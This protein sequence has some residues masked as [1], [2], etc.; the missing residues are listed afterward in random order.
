MC[1]LVPG[2][3]DQVKLDEDV[4]SMEVACGGLTGG[5]VSCR[6]CRVEVV[7][8]V[9]RFERMNEERSRRC[10]VKLSRV[11]HESLF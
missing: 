6:S 7:E 11:E 8:Q 10:E 9:D 4:S 3:P 1:D 2:S 5:V